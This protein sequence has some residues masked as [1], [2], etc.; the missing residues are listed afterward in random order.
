MNELRKDF[1]IPS[2]VASAHAFVSGLG[3]YQLFLNGQNVDPTRKLDPAWTTFEK[4]TL[5]STFDVTSVLSVGPN[6]IGVMLG[7]GWYT[8]EQVRGPFVPV[9]QA[10]FF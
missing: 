6:A 7:N 1:S 3:Y 9:C 4:R 10:V 2:A 8:Q 5:Y